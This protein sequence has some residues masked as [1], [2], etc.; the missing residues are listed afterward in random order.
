MRLEIVSLVREE[1][2]L[3]QPGALLGQLQSVLPGSQASLLWFKGDSAGLYCLEVDGSQ[4]VESVFSLVP[5]KVK[6]AKGKTNC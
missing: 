1:S 6:P 3:Q 5:V 4:W 2:S